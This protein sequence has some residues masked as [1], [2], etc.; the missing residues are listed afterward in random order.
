MM[1]N[2]LLILLLL[3]SIGVKAQLINNN[4]YTFPKGLG[5]PTGNTAPLAFNGAT[6]FFGTN[7]DLQVY[8]GSQWVA[9]GSKAFMSTTYVP[10]TRSITIN[11]VTQDLS[12]NRT[13][14]VSTGTLTN[15]TATN[16]TGQTFTITNPTTTPNISLTLTSAA[17]GLG[18]VENKSS[19]TIRGEITSGN[20]TTA[21]G[22]TPA[23]NA[24]V[25]HLAGTEFFS[26]YKRFQA[27]AGIDRALYMGSAANDNP[28]IG[29]II[30]MSN[31]NDAATTTAGYGIQLGTG[32]DLIFNSFNGAPGS[33]SFIPRFRM[34]NGGLLRYSSDMSASYTARDVVDKAYVD[35]KVLSTIR[36]ETGYVVYL[37]ATGNGS[38]TTITIPHGAP[39]FSGGG[40]ILLTAN[41]D[42]A[43]NFKYATIDATNIYIYYS[44]APPSGSQELL[45]TA[46]IKPIMF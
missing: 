10:L 5:I 1:K 34:T 32:S 45:Y 4:P 29:D 31:T 26:G 40:L 42:K 17:V 46:L 18:N 39:G 15:L 6:W 22:Y 44:V 24:L 35:G 43:A 21:L 12:T 27:D 11:G 36:T 8:N 25:A 37:V 2:K 14:T 30:Q 38:S 3:L 23:N 33:I 19:A 13:F 20:V 7:Q 16:G 9:F 28:A 41:S